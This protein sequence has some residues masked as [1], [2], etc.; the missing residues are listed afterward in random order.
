MPTPRLNPERPQTAS[1]RQARHRAA[2]VRRAAL[3]RV[4]LEQV[5]KAREL[6]Q[7][8]AVAAE[9]LRRDG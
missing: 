6:E 8:R 1:E 7:A 2:L 5:A 4:A 3:L 9:A